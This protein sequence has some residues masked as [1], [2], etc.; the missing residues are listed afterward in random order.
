MLR[1]GYRIPL[2]ENPE[3]TT[4]PKISSGYSSSVMDIAL[5]QAIRALE[6]K[7]AIEELPL[8]NIS[9]GFYNRLFL[10]PKPDG[11]WRPILDLKPLNPYV[12]EV[13]ESQETLNQ[14]RASLR[15]GQ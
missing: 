5:E 4:V 9:R 10:R 2:K 13:K 3:L 7:G 15:Q 12:E 6:E 14:I 1:W 11:K 8:Q